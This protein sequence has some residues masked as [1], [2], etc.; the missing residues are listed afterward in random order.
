MWDEFDPQDD[1]MAGFSYRITLRCTRCTSTR[2]DYL[3]NIGYVA[4]RRYWHPDDY[5]NVNGREPHATMRLIIV[6]RR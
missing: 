3:D 4:S 6:K 2:F 5:P 1:N